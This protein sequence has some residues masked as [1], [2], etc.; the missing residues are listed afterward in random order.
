MKQRVRVQKEAAPAAEAAATNR[1]TDITVNEVSIVDRAANQR[2]YL[3][4]KDAPPPA[5]VAPPP[6]AAPPVAP[7]APPQLKISPE[8]KA[9]IAGVLTAAQA[10]ITEIAKAL[11]TAAETPG[12]PAPQELIDALT[13]LSGMFA[14]NPAAPPAAA[15]PAAHPAPPPAAK[16]ET[17]KAGKKISAARLAQL[18]SAKEAID[19]IIAEVSDATDDD[20]AAVE[21]AKTEKATAAKNEGGV[22]VTE[23]APSTSEL[24]GIK[25]SLES[26]AGLV[27]K[28]TQVF[29]G[30]N[31]RI[32]ALA[33]ARGES[34]Q[35][36]LE[37]AGSPPKDKPVVWDMDM[38]RPLK[39]V[40]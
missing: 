13:G 27:G 30:Q 38:A 29:E 5:A 31:Q 6:A 23:V 40:Q 39:V 7:P 25:A 33:K 28:M 17:A 12:A 8:L 36:D 19:T 24:D 21:P 37:K 18:M 3:I 1:L 16:E 22:G 4:V 20:A 35:L 32:D 2:K 26:L 34:K 10:K 14:A 11:Q 15:P 9:K